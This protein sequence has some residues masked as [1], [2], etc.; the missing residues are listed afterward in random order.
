MPP[1]K[2]KERKLS[3]EEEAILGEP[4]AMDPLAGL[5]GP[6]PTAADSAPPT[7]ARPRW[8]VLKDVRASY[9]GQIISLAAGELLDESSYDLKRLR[10]GG[11]ELERA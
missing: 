4:E 5:G 9:F 1:V 11:V 2:S 7:P 10:D 8:K 3:P 6:A